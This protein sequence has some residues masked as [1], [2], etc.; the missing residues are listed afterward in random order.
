MAILPRALRAKLA[1]NAMASAPRARVDTAPGAW[2]RL[3]IQ[4][5]FV[6]G[7]IGTSR[8]LQSAASP[9]DRTLKPWKAPYEANVSTESNPPEA[10]AWLPGAHE[11]EGWARRPE[12]PPGEGPQAAVRLGALEVVPSAGHDRF[13]RSSR[14][15]DSR[16]YRRL[17]ATGHRTRTRS[18][19]VLTRW[20]GERGDGA[21]AQLGVTVSRRVGNAVLRNRVKRAIREWFRRS[22]SDRENPWEIIVI[23]REGAGSLDGR[24]IAAELSAAL[25]GLQAPEGASR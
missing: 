25:V 8:I 22:F 17:S 4:A 21:R 3:P 19:V 14:L 12:A 24:A 23:A 9:V 18:F 5:I 10:S 1:C 16:D 6:V 11:H 7:T 13:G 20:A 2:I 15:R